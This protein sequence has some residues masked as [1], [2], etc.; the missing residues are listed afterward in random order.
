MYAILRDAL[1]ALPAGDLENAQILLWGSVLV[2][3]APVATRVRQRLKSDFSL[4][5]EYP[6][7]SALEESLRVARSSAT[8]P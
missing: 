4:C 6:A 5:A 2:H 7:G 8:L 1:Q 3:S